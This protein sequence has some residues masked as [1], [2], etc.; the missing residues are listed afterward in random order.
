T[1]GRSRC[2]PVAR[3]R[4]RRAE[5]CSSSRATPSTSTTTKTSEKENVATHRNSTHS[6]RAVLFVRF[7][8]Q[9]RRM[10]QRGRPS[11]QRQFHPSRRLVRGC[12]RDAVLVDGL[13]Y[14]P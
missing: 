1:A 5:P 9:R 4:E 13:R 11:S 10:A 12:H 3:R 2:S 7:L 8:P 6:H 14:N